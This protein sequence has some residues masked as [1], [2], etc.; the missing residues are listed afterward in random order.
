MTKPKLY[1][2]IPDVASAEDIDHALDTIMNI[3]DGYIYGYLIPDY[4]GDF[5]I[6]GKI[7]EADEYNCLLTAWMPVL[8]DTIEE[9]ADDE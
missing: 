9:V 5:Y 1:R 7:L 8:A 3:K 2:A 4:H 6:V